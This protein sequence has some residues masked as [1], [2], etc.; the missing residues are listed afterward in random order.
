MHLFRQTLV[1]LVVLLPLAVQA[2][3]PLFAGDE[4][5]QLTMRAPFDE[6]MADREGDTQYDGSLEFT[7]ESGKS[8]ELDVKY[9]VR[10]RYRARHT[11]CDFAPLRVNFKKKQVQGTIFAGQDK[12]KLVTY[13][14]NTGTSHEQHIL[15]EF[16]TYRFLQALTEHSFRTR[17]LSVTYIDSSGKNRTRTRYSFFIEHRDELAQR[18]AAET[19]E[20]RSVKYDQLDPVQTSL[21]AVFAYF[22]GNTDFSAVLGPADDFC[23]HNVQLLEK[24]PGVYLPIP[25]DFDMSGMVGA[26]YATPNPKYRLRSVRVRLYRGLCRHNDLL[27]ATFAHFNDTRQAFSNIINAFEGTTNTT[28]KR[29][30]RYIDD[31]YKRINHPRGMEKYFTEDCSAEQAQ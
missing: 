25:Y 7:D 17:L 31:F 26:P 28:R 5:L 9:R 19:V 24:P 2:Q 10:G 1:A 30:Q 22:A 23:C 3:T 21:I 29:V 20:V 6:I 18:L 4:V 11:T 27:P 12:L 14:R 13:C 8:V 16:L 15:R